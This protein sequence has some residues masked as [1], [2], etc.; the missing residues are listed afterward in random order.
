MKKRNKK[1]WLTAILL[2]GAIVIQAQELPKPEPAIGGPEKQLKE[3][4]RPPRGEAP[5]PDIGRPEEQQLIKLADINGTVIRPVA[6]DR[7]EYNGL[8]IKT[9][10]GEVTV[11]FPP[12]S[13]EQI[14]SIAKNGKMVSIRGEAFTDPKGMKAFRMASLST[15]GKTTISD[16]PPLAPPLAENPLEKSFSAGI[17]ALNYGPENNVIG[18]TLTSG[19]R[20]SIAP[21][22]AQQLSSQLKANE[23]V[24]VTGIEEPKRAGV[25]YSQNTTFIKA[26]TL[27]LNGQTYL[28]R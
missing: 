24:T 7:F 6:N 13:G 5:G 12:H 9:A 27:R 28:I 17:K 4:P 11:M 1:A 19:E 23:K 14:L 15:S 20:V 18:F 26:R 21:H 2:T 16:R 10:T 22:I 3:E 8:L 25:V